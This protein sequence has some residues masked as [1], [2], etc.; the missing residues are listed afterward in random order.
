MTK[1]ELQDLFTKYLEGKAS[2]EEKRL[3][4]KF[5]AEFQTG[6]LWEEELGDRPS[7]EANLWQGVNK[8]IDKHEK[9]DYHSKTSRWDL[10][11][12]AAAIA[13]IAAVGIAI[14]FVTRTPQ[15]NLI[16]KTTTGGQKSTITLSDG[17]QIRLNAESTLTYPE[18]FIGVTREISLTGEAFFDVAR[19]ESRPF[20][21]KSGD[22]VTTVLGTTFNVKAFPDED[23]AVTVASGRVRVSSSEEIRDAGGQGKAP[24]NHP[25]A[26][27]MAK[28]AILDPG[29][30]AVYNTV[31]H[32]LSKAAVDI[33]QYIVWK[34]G[35]IRFDEI[36]LSEAI[37]ILE[38]W[39]NVTIVL[40]R[41]ELGACYIKGSYQNERLVHILESLKFVSGIDY[42]FQSE[43]AITI[44]GT[45]CTN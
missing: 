27:A 35:I 15:A 4:K 23:I 29:Q 38:R 24:D 25:S 36:R 11:H 44:T 1:K 31:S 42:E 7:V 34:D 10:W 16:V 21:I 12:V 40:E 2:K 13:L 17:S 19:D 9:E 18:T 14:F 32:T 43:S 20:I 3:L 26:D 5:D 6:K 41:P 45:N 33:Q 37:T 22:V 8:K 28:A 30:Q 39:F